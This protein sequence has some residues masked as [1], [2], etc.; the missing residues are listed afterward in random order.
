M[1]K[2]IIIFLFSIGLFFTLQIEAFAKDNIFSINKY[3]EE[4]L[5]FIKDSYNEK[6]AKDG[7]LVGGYYLKE[8]IE[9]ENNIYNDYQIIVGKYNKQ[10][11]L[12][13][14]YTYGK[15]KEDKIDDIVYSY[16]ETGKIDG[17]II[18]LETTHD[19]EE[20]LSTTSFIKLNLNG[21]FIS[22]K[23]TNSNINIII[24]ILKEDKT[25]DYYIGIGTIKR[26]SQEHSLTVKYD[27]DLN[28]LWEK[29]LE[30]E[31][32]KYIDIVPIKKDNT[33]SFALLKE[34]NDSN[35]KTTSIIKQDIDGNVIETIKDKIEEYDSYN[36]AESDKGF[37]LYGITSEVKLKKGEKS[38]YIVKYNLENTEEWESIGEFPIDEKKSVNLLSQKINEEIESYYLQYTNPIDSSLEVIELDSTGLFQKKVK[39]ISANYYVIENFLLDKNILYFVGQINCMTD[40]ACD[41]NSNS[42]FL[43]SDEDKVIEVKDSDSKNIL[44]TAAFIVVGIVGLIYIKRK[45]RLT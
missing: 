35:Q 38:Y 26:E 31:N 18:I 37:I 12:L 43:I 14:K 5:T 16:D 7:V 27:R 33:Y 32:A 24:P 28:L 13:W 21:E 2:V 8:K 23:I 15:T 3:Q 25:L 11:K 30:E 40:D 10:G 44:I 19:L 1:K 20:E 29:E 22:E 41:Y 9:K 6:Q 34:K 39:K 42:L 36:L 45:K 17:Y 4:N